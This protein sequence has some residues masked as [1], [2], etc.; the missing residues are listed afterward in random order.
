MRQQRQSQRDRFI[1]E[2]TDGTLPDETA[3]LRL[4]AVRWLH[5]VAYHLWRIRMHLNLL[6]NDAVGPGIQ[7]VAGEEAK[8]DAE[9]D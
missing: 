6:G 1:S 2:A 8:L 9:L 4:D 3:W 5:R 7:A